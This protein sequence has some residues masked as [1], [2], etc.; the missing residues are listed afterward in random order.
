MNIKSY[1]AAAALSVLPLSSNAGIIYEW[2][3]TND[4]T[5]TGMT[6]QLEFDHKTVKS[7]KFELD[8]DYDFGAGYGKVPSRGLVALLVTIPGVSYDIDYSS[9][10]RRGYSFPG[11]TLRMDITFLDDGFLTGQIYANDQNSHIDLASIGRTFTVLDANSD[12]GTV[13]AGCGWQM[14]EPT[15]C[16]GATGHIQKVREIPEPASIAL[17]VL[18]AAGLVSSRRRKAAE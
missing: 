10:G 18:G 15:P 5:P 16:A 13:G 3:A 2:T 14:E 8:L 11:G 1:L 17:L 4:Q 7:G 12:E 9:K 6:L